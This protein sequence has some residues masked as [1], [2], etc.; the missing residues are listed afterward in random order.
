M[1]N[2]GRD[3]LCDSNSFRRV[4]G[5]CGSQGR[6]LDQLNLRLLVVQARFVIFGSFN[7]RFLGLLQA[8]SYFISVVP[9]L[10]RTRICLSSLAV[11]L[12]VPCMANQFDR[13][14]RPVLAR[15]CFKCHG[16]DEG[17]REAGLRLD[18]ESGAKADLG[19]YAAVVSRDAG[20]S[21]LIK[22]VRSDDPDLRMPPPESGGALSASEISILENWIESGGDYEAH[23][24]FVAPTR[25]VIPTVVDSG[26]CNNPIDHFILHRLESRGLQPADVASRESLIR[27]VH[28][29]LTGILPDPEAVDCF[30]V[31]QDPQAYSRL[32]DQLLSSPEYAERFARPWLDLARYSDTN[33]YEKDRPRTI[34]PY[35]DWVIAAIA[36][37]MPFDQFSIEQLA[38]D[39]LPNATNQQRIATGFHRNTMLNEEGGIDPME[40]RYQAVVD[41]VATTGTV[42]M[43]MTT[44]CAQ[45][46]THKYD[47]ITHTDYFA[48]FALLNN[49]DE[50]DLIVE[51]PQRDQV[52]TEIE[53]QI[54]KAEARLARELLPNYHDFLQYANT[55]RDAEGPLEE[56]PEVREAFCDWVRTQVSQ[57]RP[58]TRLRPVAMQSTKPELTLSEDL[59]ILASGDVT[60]REV[61]GLRYRLQDK[62]EPY[63]ALRLEVLPD[64]SLPAGGPGLA[65]YEGRRGDFFLS[66][67]GIKFKGKAI[68][69]VQPSHSFGEISVGSGSADA[70][71]VIDGEGSTG[72]S[73]SG[74]EGTTN[75]WVG[76]FS[77]PLQ[78]PGELEI[79]L[80]FER[81]FAAG[82]GRFRFSV[83]SGKTPASASGLP[84]KMYDWHVDET[85]DLSEGDYLALQRHFIQSS[86]TAKSKRKLIEQLRDSIPEQVRTLGMRD[87]TKAAQRVTYR[88]HRGE[89]LQP[90]EPVEP[91]LPSMFAVSDGDSAVNRLELA[92]WLVSQEN[93][94]V[95][96]VTVNRA[97]REFFGRG[98]VDTAGDFGTQSEPPSHP[99]LLDW[100]A[101]E[102]RDNGWSLKRLHRIM[103]LSATYGQRIREPHEADPANRLLSGMSRR[104]LKAE[105]IRDS[106]LTASGLLMRHVGGPSVFPPQ[107]ASVMQLAYGAPKWK[108][109]LGADRYRRSLYTFSKR[110]APFAAFATFDGP[111]GETC[112]ARRASST[113]PLQALTLLNDEMYL[114][115][116]EGLA[117][118]SL[119][120]AGQDAEP[121]K[122]AKLMFRRLLARSPNQTELDAILEFHERHQLNPEAWTLIA[123][124]LMNTDEA[125]A[126]P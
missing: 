1:K 35:R 75:Q 27:R 41:R 111:S 61:Y 11:V 17:A 6:Y 110:T 80:V 72:W 83:S 103:V 104:R 109:S 54:H 56:I 115:F 64:P 99:G 28:L 79:E 98:I 106:F 113:T 36:S 10:L 38:G 124:A 9:C 125:I 122:I 121:A 62:V 12:A 101:V 25:P 105:Q 63:S 82:L 50:P 2:L 84:A 21:E 76:N 89:Y 95:G 97:W 43:G 7:S 44:G 119:K 23:W 34:W 42:W 77:T 48:L 102:L 30:L 68:D 19:G 13:E 29:D 71:N 8:M 39:M 91:S 24:A 59:S 5:L 46:H 53:T 93:P 107:P 14:V 87:R 33:G 37:D 31:D 123:R 69:L 108:T 114:E 116:A 112:L 20:G 86:P 57:S 32:V 65:F 100:L 81:H 73:T 74:A 40:Y 117:A 120:T 85:T 3:A 45:C 92:K 96:R 4:K 47:P 26:W 58:W 55:K 118:T 67:M 49:A 66:E 78:G 15:H 52:V 60:K 16:P 22:R 94:L 90:R 88:H 70:Q 18:L 51:Q 126:A